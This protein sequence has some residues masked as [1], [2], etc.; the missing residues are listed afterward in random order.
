MTDKAAAEAEIKTTIQW[1]NDEASRIIDDLK[2][3]QG[4][5][6]RIDDPRNHV[7]F[8]ELHAEFARRMTAI[9]KKY[10]LFKEE[11]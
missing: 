10:G 6:Y 1:L 5:E 8:K 3:E 9:G 4:K 7:A 2:A 11:L